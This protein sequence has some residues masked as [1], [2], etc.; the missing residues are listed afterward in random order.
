MGM[1][2]NK[3]CVSWED[4]VLKHAPFQEKEIHTGYV[5]MIFKSSDTWSAGVFFDT[6]QQETFRFVA[7]FK[8]YLDDEVVFTGVWKDNTYRGETYRQFHAY[9]IK[10]DL[11]LSEEGLYRF[12]KNNSDLKGI[13]EKTAK[14]IANKFWKNFNDVIVNNPEKISNSVKI[15]K[16]AL[17][18]L[19]RIWKE[20]ITLNQ[21]TV[22]LSNLE[23]PYNLISKIIKDYNGSA[24]A[25][26][27]KNPYS[28]IR[29][30][31]GYSFTI[32]DKVAEKLNFDKKSSL[33]LQ[34]AI[35]Y[36]LLSDVQ[37]GFESNDCWIEINEL[38]HKMV[39]LL[40]LSYDFI[41][42]FISND[43]DEKNI[44]LFEDEGILKVSYHFT[45]YAEEYSINFLNGIKD[46]NNI[47]DPE[48][49]FE[50]Y[51]ES[52]SIL[53]EKQKL[54]V[55]NAL[56]HNFSI[57]TG[58]A[59]TGKTFVIKNLIHI[60]RQIDLDFALVAP[61]G[62]AAK[63]IEESVGHEAATIHRLLKYN[64]IEYQYNEHEKIT[65]YDVFIVDEFS[66]VNNDLAYRLFCALPENAKVIIVGDHNQ[67]PPIGPG[68]LFTEL[69]HDSM[70]KWPIVELD[71]IVRQAGNLKKNS[72]NILDSY[73]ELEQKDDWVPMIHSD[74]YS[75]QNIISLVKSIFENSEETVGFNYEDIQVIAPKKHGI[76]A[77]HNLNI[78]IQ[79]TIQQKLYGVI[80]EE[81]ANI[82]RPKFYLHDKVIQTSNDYDIDVMNGTL[83]KIVYLDNSSGI[84]KIKFDGDI[85]VEYEKNDERLDN[86]SLAYALT[87]HKVQ[88]SEFPCI[89]ILMHKSQK[90]MI[91]KNLLYTA[92][93]R[94][95]K[96]ALIVSD[97]ST[98]NF[99]LKK[100]KVINKKT[101]FK[102]IVKNLNKK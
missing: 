52:L 23:I 67:L 29:Y 57:I 72:T 44:K 50:T 69:L 59:G 99:C 21:L 20:N 54:A 77:V 51:Y 31:N 76:S 80:V 11:N 32:A 27:S 65:G 58:K 34:A 45:F 22:E 85:F 91:D 82:E 95:S 93:T 62:K 48:T 101:N 47:S 87:I 16:D 96:K 81:V 5:S 38:I 64:S 79:K 40:Q 8:V 97:P 88:G 17:D 83:G 24:Y 66:M 19:V 55:K 7:Y 26:I 84:T 94:A 46:K 92:V 73:L 28:L 37:D 36:I 15:R 18:N 10:K 3:C 60:F 43:I 1:D 33:R 49:I 86:V 68:L 4:L 74:F 9:S 12:L 14:Q 63:R 90:F 70:I 78:E 25:V 98:I 56:N 35:E 89:V 13:G 75:E 41:A 2:P 39:D 6:E 71:K 61:T 30:I 42:N 100:N 102:Y 53:N